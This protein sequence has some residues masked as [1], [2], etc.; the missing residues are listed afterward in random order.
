MDTDQVKLVQVD[1]MLAI[2]PAVLGPQQDLPAVRVDQPV[3]LEAVLVRQ[4]HRKLV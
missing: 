2:D 1:G 3:M 4:R